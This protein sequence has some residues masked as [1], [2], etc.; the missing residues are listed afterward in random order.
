[1]MLISPEGEIWM[2]ES[3]NKLHCSTEH[4]SSKSWHTYWNIC[5]PTCN[6]LCRSL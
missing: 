4:H 6:I 5:W 3:Q 1:M 2:M